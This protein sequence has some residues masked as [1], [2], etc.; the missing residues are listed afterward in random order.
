MSLLESRHCCYKYP[1]PPEP[2]PWG[3]GITPAGPPDMACGALGKEAGRSLSPRDCS[4]IRQRRR[5]RS[6]GAPRAI[7]THLEFKSPSS[8]TQTKPGK[9]CQQAGRRRAVWSDRFHQPGWL[10]DEPGM[11]EVG[12]EHSRGFSTTWISLSPFPAVLVMPWD[13]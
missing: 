8:S 10:R 12:E 7:P 4:L 9:S 11:E 3:Q 1:C 5:Q 2:S 6:L 13:G